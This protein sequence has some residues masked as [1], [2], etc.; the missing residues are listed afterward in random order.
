MTE[1]SGPRELVGYAVA[2]EQVGFDFEV[3]SDHYSPWL[4]AQGHAPNA[5]PV[6]GAV[7]HATDSVHLYSYVTCPTIRYHPAVV[8]QQAAT[9]QILADGRFTLGLGTGENLNE[10]VVGQ[11]WPTIERRLDMLAEAIKIIRE[12][13]SGDLIDFR[14]EY[15]EVDSARI[16]DAPDE[17]VTIGVSMTGEKAVDKL[18]VLADH[19]VP[20]DVVVC[21]VGQGEASSSSVFPDAVLVE[22]PVA[23]DDGLVH[24][25]ERLA[26]TLVSLLRSP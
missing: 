24:D 20:V 21:P 17:P 11:G 16:W 23:D 26:A 10:H 13:L 1:Q 19:G 6:L 12:L 25:A 5:W 7:A 2:A 4:A 3:C 8:A 22:A 15:F 14:G 9:V 18:A